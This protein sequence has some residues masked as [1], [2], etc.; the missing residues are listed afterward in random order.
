MTLVS[1]SDGAVRWTEKY[2]RPI[3]NVFAVQDEIARTVA[4]TL[5]GSL[6]RSANAA[7]PR[8]ETT[9]PEA[10]ALFLQG[11]VLFN[12]RGARSTPP[13]D[14]ALPA[15]LGAGSALRPRAG[16]A[17]DGAGRASRLRAGQQHA[18]S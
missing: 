1:A 18:E 17:R 7:G 2:D 10:H 9:D 5:L 8:A 3:A 14:R 15:G 11:Q 16:V 6:R 13:G 4:G 12:R